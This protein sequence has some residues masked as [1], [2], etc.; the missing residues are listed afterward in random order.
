MTTP[1][2][3]YSLPSARVAAVVVAAL[4]AGC[5]TTSNP[6]APQPAT[7]VPAGQDLKLAA[8]NVVLGAVAGGLGALVNGEGDPPL[9]RL[10][11][12]AGWGAAGGTV[13]YF[14]KWQA[15]EVAQNGRLV[16]ALPARLLHDAG[17]SVVENAAHDRH[18]LDRFATQLGVVR[19]DVRPRS[20]EV[21]ARLLPVAA[22]A[23]GLLI[24]DGDQTLDVGRSLA[25]GGPL[26]T[27]DEV[28]PVLGGEAGQ[29]TGYAFLGSVIIQRQPDGFDY[30]VTAHELVHVMQHHE[31]VRIESAFRAPLDAGLR[32]SRAYR[33]IARWVYLD[34]P[35]LLALAYFAVE[36]GELGSPCRYNNWFEREA[37][38]F[39]ER[40][41]VPVCR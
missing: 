3:C 26:F 2:R 20:G 14:G 28:R 36:G 39:G 27:A 23:F 4:V 5:A 1:A 17:S 38:A 8:Y 24:V 19:V 40:R 11:R 32:R 15:G 10:A 35:A 6:S 41:S 9:R 31:M 34:S 21:Q 16:Y 13:V 30:D 37:E 33:D 7:G 12:G 29:F 25:Y 18:P 22:L